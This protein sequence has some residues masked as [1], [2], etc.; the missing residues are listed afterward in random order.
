MRKFIYSALFL[1]SALALASC[2]ADEPTATVNDGTV[3]FTVALPEIATRAYGDTPFCDELWYTVFDA[4]GTE[5]II[6]DQVQNPSFG[7]GVRTAE[8]NLKLVANQEYN[9]VFYAHNTGSE[10]SSYENGNVTVKYGEYNAN[11]ELDDAFVKCENFVADGN[12]KTVVLTRPFAQI[13]VGTDDMGEEAVENLITKLNGTLTVSSGLYEE[14]NVLTGE[15]GNPVAEGTSYSFTSKDLKENTDFPVVSNGKT[16]SLLTEVYLLVDQKESLINANYALNY[17]DASTLIRELNLAATPVQMNYRTNIFGTL[18]TTDQAFTVE[19][20]P[21]FEGGVA[22]DWKYEENVATVF[23]AD[24]LNKAFQAVPDGALI[25]LNN[26]IDASNL[27]NNRIETKKNQNFTLDLNGHNITNACL[28]F[29]NNSNITIKGQ[30]NVTG[31][32]ALATVTAVACTLN[33]EGGNYTAGIDAKGD[34]NTCIFSEQGGVVNISGGEF[35]CQKAAAENPDW[36]YVLNKMNG[37]AGYFS[38][39]GGTFYNYNPADGDDADKNDN[40]VAEGYKSVD[41]GDGV[42]TVEAE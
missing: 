36:Y 23:T 13:N 21:A 33:I 27:K 18:L 34:S 31:G 24:G 22:P 15:L 40:W 26:D 16:Y 32:P 11:S 2:S 9:I 25:V 6:S 7:N 30:G 10:F 39:T 17:G 14:Y 28:I 12:P 4:T 37:S 29:W 3:N 8:V 41:L 5:T 42:W 20:D 38:V 19:I 35:R 1:G